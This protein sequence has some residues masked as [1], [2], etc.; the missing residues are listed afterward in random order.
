MAPPTD[1]EPV[2]GGSS[3]GWPQHASV[4]CQKLANNAHGS[5]SQPLPFYYNFL[6]PAPR[7]VG[8]RYY[9][10]TG[11]VVPLATGEERPTPVHTGRWNI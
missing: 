8:Y 7:R 3:S 10:N 2:S 4:F 6:C 9:F 11:E 5:V 1:A